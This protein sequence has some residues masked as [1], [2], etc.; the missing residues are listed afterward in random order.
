VASASRRK[1]GEEIQTLAT[2][3][4]FRLEAEATLTLRKGR[5][6][7][8]ISDALLNVSVASAFR[9]KAVAGADWELNSGRG[10]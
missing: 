8:I 10:V 3:T 1:A 4:A 9:R 6:V 5:R 7:K 2:A